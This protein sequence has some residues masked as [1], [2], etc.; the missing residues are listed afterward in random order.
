MEYGHLTEFSY[1]LSSHGMMA[2]SSSGYSRKVT[3]NKD[4][5]VILRS[6]SSGNG[7]YTSLEYKVPPETAKTL[8]DYVADKRLADLSQ[9][10]IPTVAMYDNFTSSTICMTYDNSASYTLNCG[11][12][13]YT[14]KTIESEI[15]ELLKE[16]ESAGECIKDEKQETPSP[17]LDYYKMTMGMT[18]GAGAQDL[19]GLKQVQEAVMRE[20]NAA[21]KTPSVPG[22]WI[23][24]CGTENSGKFCWNCGMP[25]E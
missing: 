1:N 22:N 21:P 11:P 25:R 20:Q 18:P 12:A 8:S 23:C 2:G 7:S 6:S 14:F 19:E 15:S 16:C 3:W 5:S 4:G 24:K 9:E 13:G 17:F 10:D